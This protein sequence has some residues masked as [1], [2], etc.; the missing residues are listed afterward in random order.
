MYPDAG[1][2]IAGRLLPLNCIGDYGRSRPWG[3]FCALYYLR[4]KP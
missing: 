1:V 4:I 2:P 3:V